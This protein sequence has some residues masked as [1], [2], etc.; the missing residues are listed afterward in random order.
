MINSRDFLGDNFNERTYVIPFSIGAFITNNETNEL[1]RVLEYIIDSKG[2]FAHIQHKEKENIF[3]AGPFKVISM[4]NKGEE[5]VIPINELTENYKKSVFSYI[6][7]KN[8][9]QSDNKRR[10]FIKNVNKNK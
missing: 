3:G 1:F 7:P 8:Y 10:S 5:T 6:I 4:E 9:K 2:F